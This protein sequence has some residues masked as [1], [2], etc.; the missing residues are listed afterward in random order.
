ME[1]FQH[2]D[3]R[4]GRVDSALQSVTIKFPNVHDSV[5]WVDGS[6]LDWFGWVG[7][8]VVGEL[9]SHLGSHRTGASCS[10]GGWLVPTMA[11]VLPLSH[12]LPFLELVAILLHQPPKS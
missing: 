3:Q 7:P 5:G 12:L 11:E 2:I 4:E 10:Q 9:L 6:G 8:D 1:G